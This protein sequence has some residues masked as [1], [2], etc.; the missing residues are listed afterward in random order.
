[1]G[2]L[3]KALRLVQKISD[4]TAS[5]DF[6]AIRW[7][8]SATHLDS[9]PLSRAD[10]HDCCCTP[11]SQLRTKKARTQLEILSGLPIHLYV[12]PFPQKLPSMRSVASEQH[13]L[14]LYAFLLTKISQTKPFSLRVKKMHFMTVNL[15]F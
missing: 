9:I 1:M 2:H 8:L 3:S 4:E 6:N 14:K 15:F 12:A 13:L 11:R 5:E 10:K 7:A